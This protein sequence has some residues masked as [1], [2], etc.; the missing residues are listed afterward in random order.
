[1]S[2]NQFGFAAQC[3]RERRLKTKENDVLNAAVIEEIKRLETLRCAS[4]VKGDTTTLCTL[5][6]ENLVHIHANGRIEDRI[7]YLESIQNR[8]QFLDI[9][10]SDLNFIVEGE[11]VIVSGVL[12]HV[13]RVYGQEEVKKFRGIATQ[14]W[15]RSGEHWRQYAFHA[16]RLTE[17]A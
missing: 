6:S 5:I 9:A 2:P 1:M 14:V 16:T 3:F 15:I 4:L 8:V 12:E 7:T 10:R 13:A 17:R 11:T